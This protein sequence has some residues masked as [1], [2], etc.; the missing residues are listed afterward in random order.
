MGLFDFF[1]KKKASSIGEQDLLEANVC[2]N[3]WGKQDYDG[4]FV[5]YV[6]D[7]QKDVVNKQTQKAFIGKFVDTY[8][9]GI[10]LKSEGNQLSCPACKGKFKT[11]S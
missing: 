6:K 8:V 9:S 5:N 3:C 10:R 1:K 7:Q 2:P 11:V 4:Q